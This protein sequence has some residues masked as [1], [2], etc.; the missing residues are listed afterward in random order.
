MN[1][2]VGANLERFLYKYLG[3]IY[4]NSNVKRITT[5]V[6]V[7]CELWVCFANRHNLLRLAL[8]IQ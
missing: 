5:Q 3:N 4:Y 8:K 1:G 6:L 7:P 2:K